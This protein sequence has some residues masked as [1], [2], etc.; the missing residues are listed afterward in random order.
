MKTT[1][2][3]PSACRRTLEV[4]VPGEK[5]REEME[6]TAKKYARDLTVPGFRK[7][8][9]PTAVIRRR[10]Q[11]EIEEEVIER[12]SKD[13][14]WKIIDEKKLVPLH[15]PV[16]EEC[17][18]QEG[19]P[20]T[21]R[22][23]FEVKPEFSLG[24]YKGLEV[25]R[26]RPPVT[27]EVIQKSLQAL[28]EQNARYEAVEGRPVGPGDVAVVDMQRVGPDARPVGELRA[29]VTLELDSPQ[30]PEE[31]RTGLTGDSSRS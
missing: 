19:K 27:E 15:Q 2:H 30:V 10:F 31:F 4:E 11:R 28:Q 14:S 17:H 3:E 25:E 5:V 24:K 26:R 7:G 22:A 8:R 12:L 29:G 13:Y 6:R 20:L 16:V 23:A 18:Y 1:I 9:T 21:F